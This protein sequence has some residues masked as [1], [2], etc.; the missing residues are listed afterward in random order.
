MGGWGP[1]MIREWAAL[2]NSSSERNEETIRGAKFRV[3]FAGNTITSP[4][5]PNPH[6]AYIVAPV[7]GRNPDA[8]WGRSNLERNF[9]ERFPKAQLPPR[10]GLGEA[11]ADHIV[12]RDST[13]RRDF[14]NTLAFAPERALLD[15]AAER[16]MYG[17][18]TAAA[19]LEERA[20]R[21]GV[22]S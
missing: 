3:P 14:C 16:R 10:I 11:S 21:C 15:A 4:A 1:S 7:Y 13:A 17:G 20:A 8:M 9:C 12:A 19:L 22:R 18:M 5:Y 2:P 6:P